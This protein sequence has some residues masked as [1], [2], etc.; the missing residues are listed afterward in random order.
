MKRK[1]PSLLLAIL[2]IMTA[3]LPVAAVELPGDEGSMSGSLVIIHTND[4]HGRDYDGIYSTAAVS[5]LKKDYENAGAEVLLFSAGDAV[6][7][8]PLVNLEQGRL[9]I[10]FMNDAGYDAMTLGNHE[11]DWGTDN[12]NS[13]LTTASFP[14]LSLNVI[15][16]A[17][18]KP[19]YESSRI[20]SLEN[21]SK[22]GL[23]G[24][25][26][27]ETATKAHPDKVHGVSF[28][29]GK[30]LFD[31]ANSEVKKLRDN[32]CEIIIMLGH[33]GDS[34]ESTGNRSTDFLNNVSDID[35]FIDAHSHTVLSEGELQGGTLRVSAGEYLDYIGVVEYDGSKFTAALLGHV[36]ETIIDDTGA[37]KEVAVP[38]YK[39]V[40]K[41]LLSKIKAEN[42]KVEEALAETFGSTEV[43]LD[44]ERDPGVRSQETNLG[45]FAADALLWS[46]KKALGDD[47][48]DVALTN[49]GGIRASIQPGDISMKTMNTVFPFGNELTT[50]TVTGADLLEALEAATFSIPGAIAAFPQVAGMSFSIDATVDYENGEQY[51]NSSYYAPAKPGSRIKNLKIGGAPVDLEAEYVV[52]TN[53]FT[54]AGGDTYGVFK[55]KTIYKT[56]V[57]LDEALVNY[58]K[59]ELKGVI[60]SAAYGKPAGRIGIKLVELPEDYGIGQNSW[61]YDA[62]AH[63][64]AHKYMGSN[65][66]ISKDFA[67]SVA[68]SRAMIYQI[69]YNMEGRPDLAEDFV[70]SFT[71]INGKW[72][73]KAAAWA[74]EQ[75]LTKGVE[76]NRFAGDLTATR[77]E[78][79]TAFSRYISYKNPDINIPTENVI[80]EMKDYRSVP[81]WAY[82]SMNLCLKLKVLNG[83]PGKILDP[84]DKANRAEMATILLNYD[85][86]DFAQYTAESA[87][88]A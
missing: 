43:L 75:G 30:E 36:T 79:A 6:Q 86:I 71:D 21:G 49:G 83:R 65:S 19:V 37:E 48:V 35:L 31:A 51:A 58:T 7:G 14:V 39:G 40:D 1:I 8:T 61:Y 85:S 69:M 47:K 63:S 80:N 87:N 46:A 74:D 57:M 44:G 32:G 73:E 82:D 27:P 11:F 13:I 60:T 67:P 18:G 77:A 41:T 78:M 70:S 17:T 54:A 15:D 53:D 5:Q 33:L 68:I 59:T 52:V 2:L 24:V 72:Y 76:D 20:I 56:G 88:A 84:N 50:V 45:D 22:V 25:T 38:E 4:T 81:L 28:L 26:T 64:L 23:L 62:V 3:I 66:T 16:S 9:A 34:E 42:D 55:D 12:L 10:E 29:S